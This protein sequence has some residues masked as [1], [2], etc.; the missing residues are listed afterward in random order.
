MPT[1]PSVGGACVLGAVAEDR[2]RAPHMV[3]GGAHGACEE[4]SVGFPGGMCAGGCD[5]LGPDGVCGTIALLTPFNQCLARGEPFA[6]CAKQSRP[7]ALRRCDDAHPCR[8][9]YV[10]AKTSPAEGGCLPPYFVLQMRVDGH[11]LTPLPR[12]RT[13]IGR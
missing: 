7:A 1:A 12:W 11:P 9:D 6:I 13:L 2:I 10:C 4:V 3:D 5:A 8:S